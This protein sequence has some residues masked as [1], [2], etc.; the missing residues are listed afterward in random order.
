MLYFCFQ[1]LK[2][3]KAALGAIDWSDRKKEKVKAVLKT[4]FMSSES[5]DSEEEEESKRPLVIR[6]IEWESKKLKKYK[7]KL[8]REYLSSLSV[9]SLRLR[10][11]RRRS[12][13]KLSGRDVPS[14][15]PSWAYIDKTDRSN[16]EPE[17]HDHEEK[18]DTS[19]H[20]SEDVN[21]VFDFQSDSEFNFPI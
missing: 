10:R 20:I 19:A 5:S 3:R 2:S 6:S 4:T 11:P 8:D 21:D 7:K 15:I 17:E 1:K 12:E 16:A 13:S 9:K 14:T 18:R